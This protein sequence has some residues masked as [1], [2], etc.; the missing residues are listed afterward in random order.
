MIM[1]S[2]PPNAHALSP[3]QLRK[4]MISA[5]IDA[6]WPTVFNETVCRHCGLPEDKTSI[7]L[8]Y[9]P[10]PKIWIHH[11]CADPFRAAVHARACAALGF[12]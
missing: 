6:N 9:G 8:G 10:R 4:H 11:A 12:T 7:P 1:P 3:D 2:P 5:W